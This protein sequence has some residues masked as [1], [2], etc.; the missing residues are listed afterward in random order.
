MKI[1]M[2]GT[3]MVGR[4]LA[5]KLDEL[6][7]DVVIGT[8]DPAGTLARTGRDMQGRPP[9]TDWNQAHAAVR[10]AS[11]ADA[12]ARGELIVNA[13]AGVA[14]LA[15]L[16]AAGAD[17]LAGKVIMD[18]SNALDFSHGMPPTL[19]VANTDSVAEQIQRAYPASR[20]VKALNTVS[21]MVMTDPGH[22]PGGHVVFIAGDDDEAKAT[23]RGLLGEFGWAADTILDLGGVRFAR[24]PEMYMLLWLSLWGALGTPDFNIA[25]HRS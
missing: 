2:L 11:F 13:T 3:G 21:S 23:V 20:V 15:A 8:R 25:V 17:A 22:I 4:T 7:H 5:G 18:V 10:L 14:S 12:A 16:E 9:F 1:A 6:G 24:G 19:A